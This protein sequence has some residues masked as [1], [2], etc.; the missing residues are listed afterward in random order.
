MRTLTQRLQRV[1]LED[2]PALFIAWNE[3]ARALRREFVLPEEANSDLIWTLHQWT[4]AP[5]QVASAP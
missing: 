2:P 3:R 5:R 4:R 1:M